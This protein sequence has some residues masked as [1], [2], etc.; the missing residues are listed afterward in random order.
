MDVPFL[1]S[2]AQMRRIEPFFSL[3]HGMPRVDDRRIAWQVCRTQRCGIEQAWL[4]ARQDCFDDGGARKFRRT[5]RETQESLTFLFRAV[6]A[7]SILP[8]ASSRSTSWPSAYL[9]LAKPP[10]LRAGATGLG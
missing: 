9:A 7:I 3:S 10:A 4:C 5:T 1:L 6:L 2:K 8:V